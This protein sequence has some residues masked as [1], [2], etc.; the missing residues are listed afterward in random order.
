LG[1]LTLILVECKFT[2]DVKVMRKMDPYCKLSMREQEW[3]SET[4]ERGSKHPVW[5]KE[6]KVELDVKYLGDDIFFKYYDDDP[7]KDEKICESVTKVSTFCADVEDLWIDCEHKGKDAG[8]AHWLCK[9][10]PR[11]EEPAKEEHEDEMAKAQ[12][13]IAKLSARKAE[14][15]K[16]Y[17]AAQAQVDETAEEVAALEA[18]LQ[19][20]DC[21]AQYEEA[22][23]AANDKYEREMARIARQK[24]IGAGKAEEYKAELA[25][26]LE[27]AEAYRE[28]RN[29]EIDALDAKADEDKEKKLARIEEM[30]ENEEEEHAKELE[31]LEAEIAE[32]KAADQEKYDAVA[33]EIKEVA[34]QLLELNEKM[35]EYLTKMTML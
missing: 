8:K 4:C 35:Q 29:A 25:A 1:K 30:K 28:A 11:E 13:Y 2:R 14:L 24:E 19:L 16:E 33:G 6:Q 21:D 32:T 31:R 15:E 5:K 17:E 9:W 26:K 20:C 23:Q 22:V 27:K 3:K 18:G 12:E 34:E 7:G 10:E